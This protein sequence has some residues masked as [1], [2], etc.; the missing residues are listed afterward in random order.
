M[1]V[2]IGGSQVKQVWCSFKY[3]MQGSTW[4]SYLTMTG[5]V[6]IRW[7]WH[8]LLLLSMVSLVDSMWRGSTSK[9]T[10]A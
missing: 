4:T 3:S 5:T 6:Y 10:L 8:H 7:Q 1:N 2:T 9:A